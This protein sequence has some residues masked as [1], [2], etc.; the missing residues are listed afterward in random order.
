MP[1]NPQKRRCRTPGCRAW[2]RRG[3]DLCAAHSGS[4]RA[5]EGDDLF[6]P[7]LSM[8]SHAAEGPLDDV[9]VIESE[10]RQLARAREAFMR[11]L[12]EMRDAGDVAMP[13][14]QFLRALNDSTTRVVQLLR[15]RRELGGDE[16]ALAPLIKAFYDSV[17]EI[18][19]E[20]AAVQ[21]GQGQDDAARPP[22]SLL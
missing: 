11:W 3:H 15:A 7:L 4:L 16:G 8:M 22:P 17:D 2:A 1:K 18:A 6:A 21:A 5:R 9:T 10:L 20:W 14:A 13:P 19:D 12:Q